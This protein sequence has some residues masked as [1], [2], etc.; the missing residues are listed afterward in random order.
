MKALRSVLSASLVLTVFF[1]ANQAVFSQLVCNVVSPTI[2]QSG[3]LEG[4][5]ATQTG[6]INRNGITGSC[7]NGKTNSI[8]NSTQILAMDNYTYTAPVTGCATVEFDASACGG[9]TTQ[10]VAYSTYSPTSPGANVISDFGFST[11][12]TADFSF[13]V[14]NGQDF[15]IVIHDIL[16]SPTNI[17]C[18]DYTFEI[19]YRTNCR[20]PGFDKTNDGK[21]DPTFFRPGTGDWMTFDPVGGNATQNFGL[22]GDILTAGDYTGDQQTD[23]SVYRESDNTWY[24]GNDST[25]PGTNFTSQPWGI[26]GDIP[27]PGDYDGDSVADIAVWRPS[28]GFWYILQSSNS[29]VSYRQWGHSGDIPVTGDFDGDLKTDFTIVRP[30]EAGVTPEYN[31]YVVYSNFGFGFGYIYKWGT[32][33]DKIVPGD[34]DGNGKTDSA[35]FRPSNGQWYVLNSTN[36]NL[37]P[38][39]SSGFIWGLNEDIPQPGDYDGDAA[40]DVAVFRPSDG[41]WYLRNSGTN[42]SSVVNWGTATDIPATSPHAGNTSMPPMLRSASK[43]NLRSIQRKT[44]SGVFGNGMIENQLD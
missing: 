22:S 26:A 20:Q 9:A 37:P 5:D 28:N 21:A 40:M 44:T 12:A 35:V 4:T 11:S 42:T 29:T 8:F 31:W 25:S 39:T 10:A 17:L 38:A 16:D 6:R 2:V 7:P 13:P 33:G 15:T 30:D 23:V 18:G 24:Y 14:T 34:Y 36:Q 32:V 1:L 43:S 27:V 19:T 41:N 3:A